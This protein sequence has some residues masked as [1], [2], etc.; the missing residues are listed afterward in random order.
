M[1]PK[2]VYIAHPINGD[3][4]NNIARVEEILA[5]LIQQEFSCWPIA[6]Y[7][8]ACR[9]LEETEENRERCFAINKIYFSS[10]FINELWVFGHSRGVDA[11]IAWAV[12]YGIPVVYK[13][14]HRDQSEKGDQS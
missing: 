12:E 14:T 5:V 13:F 2:I 11:E 7:L 4:G 9:Y 1:I 3:V 10:R 8:D 6:P